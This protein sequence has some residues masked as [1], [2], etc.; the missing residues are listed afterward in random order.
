[1][2]RRSEKRKV[3]N[4]MIIVAWVLAELNAVLGVFALM[5]GGHIVMGI[6]HLFIGLILVIQLSTYKSLRWR[7]D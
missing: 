4:F 2:P 3:H 1:M 5:Q 6:V 7:K